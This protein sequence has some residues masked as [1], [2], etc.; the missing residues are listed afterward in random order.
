MIDDLLVGQTWFLGYIHS[1]QP[2]K[3]LNNWSSIYVRKWISFIKS[4]LCIFE[5]LE[6]LWL[7][8]DV[9]QF[10]TIFLF[11]SI[12]YPRY[13]HRSDIESILHLL[14]ILPPCRRHLCSTV[15]WLRLWSGEEREKFCKCKKFTDEP[16]MSA[17]TSSS[18]CQKIID[19]KGENIV[20]VSIFK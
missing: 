11:R 8:F 18:L 10:C 1:W 14:V 19:W 20:N 7:L 16:I 15:L 3:T 6:T 9:S 12:S 5:R 4:K 13:C 2:F 17:Y